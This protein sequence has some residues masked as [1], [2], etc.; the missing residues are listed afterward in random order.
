ML[1][2]KLVMNVGVWGKDVTLPTESFRWK[3]AENLMR[4]NSLSAR[5]SGLPLRTG[6]LQNRLPEPKTSDW[7]VGFCS[8]YLSLS[9]Y[10]YKYVYAYA[11]S[12]WGPY[13]DSHR[14]TV[15]LQ[16]KTRF[17]QPVWILLHLAARL[18]SRQHIQPSGSRWHFHCHQG[19]LQMEVTLASPPQIPAGTDG[20][21]H[22]AR[23]LIFR[24]SD[25]EE[26]GSS[27]A[28]KLKKKY[29]FWFI[30]SIF[31]IYIYCGCLAS[32]SIEK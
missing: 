4:P 5:P 31:I 11:Y 17:H 20:C 1:E 10:W 14:H 13:N 16:K 6:H 32:S 30:K 18:S 28:G 25:T 7:V 29:K 21:A 9:P 27:Q 22:N 8:L 23:L 24:C 2:Q 3:R 26:S 19:G 15:E 12:S